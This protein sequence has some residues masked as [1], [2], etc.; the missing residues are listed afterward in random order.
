[1][2]EIWK[3]IEGN[4]DLLH[5]YMISN[6]GRARIGDQED[7]L[8]YEGEDDDKFLY[9]ALSNKKKTGFYLRTIWSLVY[10]AFYDS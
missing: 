10:D 5:C 1:M 6:Y 4:E 2:Q 7:A 3:K 9:Y 8:L